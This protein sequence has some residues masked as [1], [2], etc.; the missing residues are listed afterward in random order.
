MQNEQFVT[1]L[2]CSNPAAYY[3][4]RSF[5]STLQLI[6]PKLIS[7]TPFAW[8]DTEVDLEKA[9]D[10]IY[11]S[12]DNCNAIAVD[13]EY[14]F[15]EKESKACIVS[16]MQISTHQKDYIIDCLALR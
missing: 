11:K 15:V 13:L 7:A 6:P 10:D 16:L 8:I 4:H 3:A 5:L 14:H 2:K 1:L 9:M 12:V